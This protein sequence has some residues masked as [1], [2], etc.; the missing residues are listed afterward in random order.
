MLARL[1]LAPSAGEMPGPEASVTKVVS[2]AQVQ[3]V[4]S[5]AMELLDAA[6]IIDDPQLSPANAA[7]RLS[8]LASP[9]DRIAGG[10]DEI[11]RNIISE[12]VLGL[13]GDIRVDKERPF[14]Q[15][16]M[17]R[18]NLPALTFESLAN[19]LFGSEFVPPF[20]AVF[21]CQLADFRLGSR[22]MFGIMVAA[23]PHGHN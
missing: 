12:R 21:I 5:F 18:E 2:A 16:P 4:A 11:L 3:H 7:L 9:G 8:F 10:S 22:C 20:A 17:Y 19:S 6:G 13:P 15:L 14:N 1:R 23:Q